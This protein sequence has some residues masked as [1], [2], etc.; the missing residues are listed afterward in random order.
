MLLSQVDVLAAGLS[1]NDSRVGPGLGQDIR[2]HANDSPGTSRLRGGKRIV[3]PNPSW[4]SPVL[5]SPTSISR[6]CSTCTWRLSWLGW[7][8]SRTPLRAGRQGKGSINTSAREVPRSN[9]DPSETPG[10]K[11]A[12]VYLCCDVS[13]RRR[14]L[15]GYRP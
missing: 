10:P 11:P 12:G 13:G 9:G 15:E 4:E 8:A 6:S 3:P 14:T 1:P 7:V 2:V 5:N